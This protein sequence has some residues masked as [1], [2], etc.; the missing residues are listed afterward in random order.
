M[1]VKMKE[2]WDKYWE[3]LDKLNFLIFF[4]MILDPRCKFGLAEFALEEMFGEEKTRIISRKMKNKF[5]ELVNEYSERFNNGQLKRNPF[6][7]SGSSGSHASSMQS[8]S[9]SRALVVDVSFGTRR[10]I[11]NI[12][13]RSRYL[14]LKARQS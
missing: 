4:A 10:A 9:V 6:E 1:V 3:N 8:P 14:V 7:I 5:F 2:K 13:K 12:N 11:E